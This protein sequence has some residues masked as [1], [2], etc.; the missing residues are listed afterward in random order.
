MQRA[1]FAPRRR[2]LLVRNADQTT[3]YQ[4]TEPWAFLSA[5]RAA[6]GGRLELEV[7]DETSDLEDALTA[8]LA[9]ADCLVLLSGAVHQAPT[10]RALVALRESIGDWIR[11]GGALVALH[12]GT[13]GTDRW[14]PDGVDAVFERAGGDSGDAPHFLPHPITTLPYGEP[15]AFAC[16]VVAS[17][18][19]SY[20]AVRGA[21]ADGGAVV[22]ESGSDPV[23]VAGPLGEGRVVLS[24]LLLDWH[25]YVHL[26][27]N[28][29]VW[30]T[31]MRIVDADGE[32]TALAALPGAGR[33]AAGVRISAPGSRRDGDSTGHAIDR[34]SP[35]RPQVGVGEDDRLELVP[36]DLADW[37]PG[38]LRARLDREH[39][40]SSF[41][42]TVEI[43]RR[44]S[45][46]GHVGDFRDQLDFIEATAAGRGRHAP[47]GDTLAAMSHGLVLCTRLTGADEHPLRGRLRA[48]ISQLGAEVEETSHADLIPEVPS[49]LEAAQASGD[50]SLLARALARSREAV[51]DNAAA[52][53]TG[54]NPVF[55]MRLFAALRALDHREPVSEDL[56]ARGLTAPELA[57]LFAGDPPPPSRVVLD[58][59]DVVELGPPHSAALAVSAQAPLGLALYAYAEMDRL[60]GCSST[61]VARHLAFWTMHPELARRAAR[62][63]AAARTLDVL[64]AVVVSRSPEDVNPRLR[65]AEAFGTLGVPVG[66]RG[67]ERPVADSLDAAPLRSTLTAALTTLARLPLRRA[68]NI[69]RPSAGAIAKA[70]GLG[71]IPLVSKDLLHVL[72]AMPTG[73]RI[74]LIAVC[75]VLGGLLAASIAIATAR[76][77]VAVATV[78]VLWCVTFGLLTVSVFQADV[79]KWGERGAALVEG[80]VWSQIVH[81]LPVAVT[82]AALLFVVAMWLLRRQ[83]Q[84]STA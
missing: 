69:L 59:L 56:L 77:V 73:V 7:L 41:N 57:M 60:A 40:D 43:C 29:L 3:R 58:L 6:W 53:S 63:L 76:L 68:R 83:E 79:A 64:D 46:A 20:F 11:A 72:V 82:D 38:L 22:A 17:Y 51:T 10:C 2:L 66:E 37:V 30:A 61:V 54:T 45:E 50:A 9:G 33:L 35:G 49:L 84:A 4:F 39:W 32:A 34:T 28:A 48:T 25:S 12:P 15:E 14:V 36:G 1:F 24:P 23:I 47:V 65:L 81:L 52:A 71:I 19:Y 5:V 18:G 21:F 42:Q 16:H 31:R 70:G 74:A 62:L 67:L 27:V 55:Q 26:F 44:L 13:A 75:A 78:L 80:D 8:K